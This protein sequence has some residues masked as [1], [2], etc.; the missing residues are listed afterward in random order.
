MFHREL[1]FY[2]FGDFNYALGGWATIRTVVM[3]N[4]LKTVTLRVESRTQWS[5]DEPWL[6]GDQLGPSFRNQKVDLRFWLSIDL[7]LKSTEIME[8]HALEWC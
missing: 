1:L 5:D 4:F 8:P 3:S 7:A 6:P 2:A